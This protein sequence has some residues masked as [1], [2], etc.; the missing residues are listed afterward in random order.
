M[1]QSS[2]EEKSWLTRQLET[3][4]YRSSMITGILSGFGS[5]LV[6]FLF[7]SRARRAT[8]FG[9][10]SYCCVALG[11][12]CYC[13]Y[14]LAQKRAQEQL[15]RRIIEQKL[16][17][18]G[19]QDDREI[20]QRDTTTEKSPADDKSSSDNNSPVLHEVSQRNNFKRN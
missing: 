15:F 20:Q 19:T 18:E 2:D 3:P 4:C 16:L 6:F 10:G 13:R 8:H 17:L 14:K 7:T 12:W 1:P 5:G 11:S 9:V